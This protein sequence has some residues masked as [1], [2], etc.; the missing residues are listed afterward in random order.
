MPIALANG[1]K[2]FE[3]DYHKLPS[4][5][6]P[7]PQAGDRDT[8][9]AP[10][11]SFIAILSGK[12]DPS[13]EAQNQRHTDYLEGIKPAKTPRKPGADYGW[14]DGLISAP[15]TGAYGVVDSYGKP[16]RIRL[17]TN[18]DDT[19]I[20]PNPQ[21]AAAGRPTL[22]ARVLVWSAGQ[23]GDWNTWDD[24]LTRLGG[25]GARAAG[26]GQRAAPTAR[27]MTAWG[28][29]PRK[30]SQPTPVSANGAFHQGQ[31]GWR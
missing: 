4:P 8:D 22:N 18:H 14:V 13:P 9:S 27:N 21:E 3:T 1:I 24:N 19:L 15:A 23:D 29:N 28:F 2:Q 6:G 11:H 31:F 20:N 25:F 16:Y 7:T 17:D 26:S 12:E 30:T 10:S 5:S